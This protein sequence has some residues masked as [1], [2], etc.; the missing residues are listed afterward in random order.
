MAGAIP[1]LRWPG[2][3]LTWDDLR[4]SDAILPLPRRA[5]GKLPPLPVDPS[6][7]RQDDPLSKAL[8]AGVLTGGRILGALG[9][10]DVG[11]EVGKRLRVPGR[12]A[13]ADAAAPSRA[14]AAV[15]A[16]LK[17]PLWTP[18]VGLAAVDGPDA[19]PRRNRLPPPA[20]AAAGIGAVRMAWGTVAEPAGVATIAAAAATTSR[21][22]ECGMTRVDD[23]TL[24][25]IGADSVPL[26][27]L[28]ASPDAIMWHNAPADAVDAGLRG[29]A[30]DNGEATAA[31][32]FDAWPEPVEVKSTCP[33][34]STNPH[35]RAGG[36]P[37]PAYMLSNL[38]PRDA[39]PASVVPQAMLQAVAVGAPST[40]IASNS[41][42]GAR[43]WRLPRDDT[44]L[45]AMLVDV[46]APWY[47]AHILSGAPLPPRGGHV[48]AGASAALAQRALEI[49]AAATEV[50][51]VKP[52]RAADPA[53]AFLN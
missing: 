37:K 41:V 53:C 43:I 4:A 13:P 51:V 6:K 42:L 21:V 22:L 35:R 14:Q 28:A 40:L 29:Q 47:Q 30:W 50:A 32:A 34:A 23:A 9:W 31:T 15:I 24:I 48:A 18:E 52:W 8:H 7:L 12:A 26:P 33:F 19:A 39:L 3:T 36:R 27:P 2:A 20:L 45:K 10:Q 44:F 25:L 49:A 11:G 1:N 17:Q 16:H 46:V 38:G 5:P